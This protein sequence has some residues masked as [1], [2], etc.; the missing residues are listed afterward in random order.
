L[1]LALDWGSAPSLTPGACA[2]STDAVV[3]FWVALREG[4]RSGSRLTV[5]SSADIS[6]IGF[7]QIRSDPIRTDQ[8]PSHHIT[9][10]LIRDE[11][12]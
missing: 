7:G 1:V 9:S 5:P 4:K 10:D 3:A 12:K 11:M 8:I 6:L 2:A